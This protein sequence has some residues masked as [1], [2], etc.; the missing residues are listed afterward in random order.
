MTDINTL[1]AE[2]AAPQP[3]PLNDISQVRLAEVERFTADRVRK[4]LHL[5][6]LKGCIPVLRKFGPEL[7]KIP[8]R[9]LTYGALLFRTRADRLYRR[10][11]HERISYFLRDE[12]LRSESP[13]YHEFILM[14]ER[15]RD[16]EFTP[17][18]MENLEQKYNWKRVR[19]CAKYAVN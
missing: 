13:H 1:L 19:F 18:E 5:V 6:V 3:L 9:Y 10:W 16:L 8:A 12:M 17:E 2:V 11:G 4:A 7:G 14:Y 15:I